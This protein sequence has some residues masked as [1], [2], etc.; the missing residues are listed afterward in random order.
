MLTNILHAEYHDYCIVTATQLV[1]LDIL[2]VADS[3]NAKVSFDPFKIISIQL[4][5]GCF[6]L[7]I[8]AKY[9]YK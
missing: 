7:K 2:G 9:N 4:I 5:C 6:Y 8:Y 1:L 3:F